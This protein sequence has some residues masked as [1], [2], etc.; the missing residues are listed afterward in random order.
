MRFVNKDGEAHTVT[1]RG[2]FD[3]GGLDTGDSWV[4]QFT[5]PGK[6]PYFCSLH[7]YMR[8]MVIVQQAKEPGK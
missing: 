2:G 7:P 3:S 8:G 1:V 4:H 5:R 6:Y